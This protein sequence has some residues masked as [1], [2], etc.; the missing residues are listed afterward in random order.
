MHH[1][2]ANRHPLAIAFAAA[3]VCAALGCGSSEPPAA[4][5][6]S[7]EA[8]SGGTAP[9]QGGS[10]VSAGGATD[11]GPTP[12]PDYPSCDAPGPAEITVDVTDVIAPRFVG[13][14]GQFNNNAYAQVS[15]DAGVTAETVGEM[16]EKT[17]A[18]G[19]DHVRIFWD[20]DGTPDNTQSFERTVDLAQRAGASINV[21]W[22]HGPYPDPAA[23]MKAFSDELVRLVQDLGYDAVRYITIQNEVNSTKVTMEVYEQL[24]R[25]LDEYLT[26][27]NLREHFT[28]VCGDLLRD[29]QAAWFDYMATNMADVCDGYSVHIY[30]EYWDTPKLSERL[31][32]VRAIVDGLPPA[33]QRPLYV[34][35]FGVRGY[36]NVGEPSP[37]VHADGTLIARTNINAYQ[38]AWFNILAARLGYVSTLK[39]D[40]FFAKYD[41]A[42]HY[43]SLIGAPPEWFLKPVYHST[44]AFTHSV[45]AE[46]DIVRAKGGDDGT[47]AAAF[48]GPHGEVTTFT[49]NKTEQAKELTVS[50]YPPSTPH[51]VVVW[52]GEA[53]GNLTSEVVTTTEA[54]QTTFTVP[55]KSFVAVTTRDP[56]L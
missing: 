56:K 47:L 12:P 5:S 32:E 45:D 6:T 7:S 46:W 2:P 37:G 13:F 3:A 31:T 17:I 52:H 19:P 28:F 55:R 48:R 21:T 54:C 51:H 25:L 42:T 20:P 44:R 30:W 27:A 38:H 36:K 26:A 43:W 33:S 40:V 1:Q 23:Q 29:G 16:E 18:L 4:P 49:L 41:N 14:G 8:G 10:S 53:E 39:W 24:Y 9:G 50:G 34:T 15:I 11:P 35:E 22:W